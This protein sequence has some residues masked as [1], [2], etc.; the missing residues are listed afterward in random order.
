ME[1]L[2][3]EIRT[4]V[5][6]RDWEQFHAPKNLAIAV[7]VEAAEL[8]EPFMWLTPD[9]SR[10]APPSLRERSAEEAADVFICLM[11]LCDKLGIDLLEAA[12][13]KLEKNRAKYPVEKAKGNAAKYDE[14]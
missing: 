11:M 5:I 8:L 6:E 14:L 1:A 2:L 9:E 4:F 13:R 10:A 3:D 12:R 7:A